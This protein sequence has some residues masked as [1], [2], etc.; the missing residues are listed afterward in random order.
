MSAPNVP[1]VI[2]IRPAIIVHVVKAS[3]F[4]LPAGALFWLAY[5]LAFL[6]KSRTDQTTQLGVA[7][8]LAVLALL[9]AFVS[10]RNIRALIV[11]PELLLTP[12]GFRVVSWDPG[13]MDLLLP[14]YRTVERTVAWS[15]LLDTLVYTHR[16]NGVVTLQE[17]RVTTRSHGKFSFG[18]VVFSPSVQ[19]IQRTML[20]YVDECFR[21]PRRAAARLPE[22]QRRRWAEPLVL[23]GHPIHGLVIAGGWILAV[24]VT[25]AAALTAF[26][27]EH[28]WMGFVAFVALVVAAGLT[29]SWW[30]ATR[31][32]YLALGQSGLA[33]GPDEARSRV[34]PWEQIRFV[35]AHIDQS[36]NPKNPPTKC[37]EIRL[38]DGKAVMVEERD[39]PD[40]QRI[41]AY[42]EPPLDQMAAVWTQLEQGVAPEAAAQAGGLLGRSPASTK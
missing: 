40:Y 42:L 33:V 30:R 2:S 6:E 15:D 23:P 25:L 7:A 35:R 37:V 41:L 39:Q 19:S 21:A 26:G 12:D 31:C 29:R 18:R 3:L 34:I 9:L 20:D 13:L 8:G 17:L 36:G 11:P 10:V 1:P 24:A 38:S 28:D 22:F 5:Q 14:Y 27:H 4:G 16:V 32:R